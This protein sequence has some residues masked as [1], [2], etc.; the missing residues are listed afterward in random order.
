VRRLLI[1][2]GTGIIGKAVLEKIPNNIT[3]IL[4]TRNPKHYSKRKN[5]EL[6]FF[7]HWND[8]SLPTN[9]WN[10]NEVLHMAGATHEIN[11]E[12]YFSVNTDLTRRLIELC[13]RNKIN[14]FT[15]MSSQAVSELGGAYSKSKF[16]AEKMILKSKLNWTILRPSEVYGPEI[17]CMLTK[18]CKLVDSSSCIPVIG[19]GLYC[20]N[21]VHIDDLSTFITKLIMDSSDLSFKKV[22]TLC[23]PKSETFLEFCQNIAVELNNELIFLKFPLSACKLLLRIL[24]KLGFKDIA[25]DQIDRLVMEKS[26]DFSSAF[27]DF[28][29]EPRSF[30]N[31]NS[32]LPSK[33]F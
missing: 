9:L 30:R 10:A 22:Y 23:G 3:I 21:P 1:T 33:D 4:L 6:E 13:E 27:N 29:F 32:L 11:P 7:D 20:L 28:N 24:N 14:R 15:Y 18:L 12:I 26:N 31:I 8:K 5:L 25:Y 19:D 17:S 2:G 16:L